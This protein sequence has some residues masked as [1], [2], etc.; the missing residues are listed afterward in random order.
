HTV[1]TARM[2][3]A[4]ASANSSQLLLRAPEV[5]IPAAS[6]TSSARGLMRPLGALPALKALTSLPSLPA[7]WFSIDSASTLRAELWVQRIRMFVVIGSCL[8]GSPSAARG[9]GTGDDGRRLAARSRGRAAGR[10]ARVGA[11]RRHGLAFVEYGD[12]AQRVEGLPGDALR[13][14]HP[15]LLA[16]GVA[17]GRLAFVEQRHVGGLRASLHL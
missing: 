10:L 7:Q 14:G 5:S 4:S 13:I 11:W 16:A 12:A 8:P 9:T 17:T 2:R 6:S 3:G 1:I 15:V